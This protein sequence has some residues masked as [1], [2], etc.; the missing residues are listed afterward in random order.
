MHL[1]HIV[2]HKLKPS[3]LFTVVMLISLGLTVRPA[4]SAPLVTLTVNDTTDLSDVTPGDGICD[5]SSGTAGSQCSLRAAIQELNAQGVAANPHR[6]EFNIPGSAPFV[7]APAAPLPLINVPVVIDGETQ[8]GSSCANVTNPAALQIVVDGSSAGVGAIGLQ[9]STGS[10]GSTLRGLVIGNFQ[11]AGIRLSS[12][13]N[14][15]RCDYIGIGADGVTAMPNISEGVIVNGINNI[16]GG[17]NAVAQRNV[18]SGNGSAGLYFTGG[19]NQVGG[20]YIGTSADGMT[21]VANNLG[22]YVGGTGN[23][24]GT[25]AVLGRNLISGN[26]GAGVRLNNSQSNILYGNYIGVAA[27]GTT[28]LPNAGNG[29]EVMGGAVSNI[30]GGTGPGQANLI[31]HNGLE[32]ISLSSNFTGTP[33]QITFRG[34]NIHAN[35][36][37]GIN[38]GSNSVDTNDVGDVDTGENDFQNYPVLQMAAGSTVIA[39]SL[40]S[41]A[42]TQYTIDLYKNVSCDPS[43]YGEGQNHIYVGVVTTDGFGHAGINTDLT[44]LASSGKSITATATDPNGNTS[45]FSSCVLIPYSIYLPVTLR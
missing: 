41:Q 14:V 23:Q 13:N 32:G 22:I 29:I 2:S 18:I 33:V 42:N 8:P 28:S 4:F 39:I 15:I 3:I 24:I 21:P 35:N 10:D 36:N 11:L 20:N 16:I 5:T 12:S 44:G 26:T 34:N 38:L 43:G 25:T 27:D 37:L 31:A 9:L 1:L 40:D 6:I 30:I 7:I 19:Y 17:Q 45:E